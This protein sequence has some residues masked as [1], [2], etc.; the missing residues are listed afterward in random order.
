MLEPVGL[1]RG[2]GRRP[3]GITTFPYAEGRCLVWDAT[4]VDTFSASSVGASAANASSAATA[5]EGRKRRRYADISRRY[6]FRPI[7]VETSG[8]LGPESLSFVKELGQRIAQTSGDRRD[9]ERLMQRISVA[10]VRGNSTA[11]RLAAQQ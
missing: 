7:A 1:D 9:R 4:C 2:D 8:A 11:V 10:V 6:L 3:D 5:A